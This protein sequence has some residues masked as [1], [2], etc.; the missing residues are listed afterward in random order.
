MAV[1]SQRVEQF[2]GG[3]VRRYGVAGRHIAAKAVA[4]LVVGFYAAAQL[5]GLHA[6]EEVRVAALHIG[7]PDIDER[8][9]Q[10]PA[11]KVQH[12]SFHHED[13]ALGLALVQA[14]SEE[15]TSELQSP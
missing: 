8:M 12:P 10:R 15:H 7:M 9:R 6:R 2:R 13:L 14:R 1:A 3:A 5:V 4:A 11:V